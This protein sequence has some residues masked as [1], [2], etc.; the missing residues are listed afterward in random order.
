MTEDVST[1]TITE[2]AAR[3]GFTLNMSEAEKIKDYID[4][5]YSNVN[6]LSDIELSTKSCLD[7]QYSWP[8]DQEDPHNIFITKCSIQ[9]QTNGD[10]SG[11]EIGIKDNIA[12]AG[13]PM[14]C[15]SP[16]LENFIPQSDAKVVQK[17]ID[18]GG[19]IIGKTNMDEFALGGDKSTMRFKVTSNPYDKTR[20]PGGSSLGS[21]AGVAKEIFDVALGT[22]TGGSVR[23][24][25]S[26]SGIVGIKPTRGSV[27]LN[28]FV[29]YAQTLDTIGILS[30]NVELNAQT[31][32]IISKH[33]DKE[34]MSNIAMRSQSEQCDFLSEVSIGLPTELFG[35]HAKIDKNIKQ[36][37]DSLS[38][39][40][41]EVKEVSIP[42]A[43]YI[44]P[45]W[46]AIS[47]AEFGAYLDSK[48]IQYWSDSNYSFD[49]FEYL[50]E[51]LSKSPDKLGTPIRNTWLWASILREEFDNKYYA[52]AQKCREKIH[53]RV[54]SLLSDVDF[55]ATPTLPMMP[56]LLKD[57][58]G[59]VSK[60]V[61]NTGIFN[62]TG[63]PAVSVPCGTIRSLPIGI[64][65]ATS[66]HQE[67]HLF[68]IASCV[69]NHN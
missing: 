20:H 69:Q 17:I 18:A 6:K 55:L 44:V 45:S 16:L 22:D 52:L 37:V 50:T 31:F 24:P 56:P 25:A 14:T 53:N 66:Y 63:H 49:L 15:G 39:Q 2:L 65:F 33:F 48:S 40:G 10:L 51:E 61:K 54:E 12:V 38:Q 19:H 62:L 34:P 29:Q 27:S 58:F 13:I 26:W 28:G 8:T 23:I 67:D 57:G 7:R 3:Q 46:L 47:T 9:N 11:L 42:E 59:D 41:A 35:E 32:S 60:V 21:G 30:S 4:Q 64:Q 36:T 43:G 1:D 68:R 5:Q